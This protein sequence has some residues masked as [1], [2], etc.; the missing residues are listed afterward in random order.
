MAKKGRT[1][2]FTLVF[3]F[4]FWAETGNKRVNKTAEEKTIRLA[5]KMEMRAFFITGDLVCL[6]E[7]IKV[8]FK[9]DLPL[10]QKGLIQLQ[11]EKSVFSCNREFLYYI[12]TI[13]V[14]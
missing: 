9:S 12:C 5:G 4:R 3:P 11:K 10:V 14:V 6:S 8:Q 2:I 1:D 7:P 13:L